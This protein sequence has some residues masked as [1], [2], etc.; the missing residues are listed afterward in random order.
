MTFPFILHFH[1]TVPIQRQIQNAVPALGR[2]S[3]IARPLFAVAD[4]RAPFPSPGERRHI[5]ATARAAGMPMLL[6][7]KPTPGQEGYILPA[8]EYAVED[9]FAGTLLYNPIRSDPSPAY[10]AAIENAIRLAGP[11]TAIAQDAPET[12]EPLSLICDFLIIGGGPQSP[13]G[14]DLWTCPTT[15]ALLRT[16]KHLPPH[17]ISLHTQLGLGELSWNQSLFMEQTFNLHH[18]MAPRLYPENLDPDYLYKLQDHA[19]RK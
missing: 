19:E 4:F 16:P 13:L 2:L 5:T 17:R 8:A 11:T 15:K 3:K 18:R 1:G 6:T 14:L 9:G 7:L 10:T 12:L